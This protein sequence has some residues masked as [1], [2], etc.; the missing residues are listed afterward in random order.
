[1]KHFPPRLWLGF[2]SR[3]ESTSEAAFK[4][5]DRN[6]E[7]YKKSLEKILP[8]LSPDAR[9]FFLKPM[10]LHDGTL[11]L[12]EVG[13]RID[14]VAARRSKGDWDR[15]NARVR[16]FVL[17]TAG[18]F[19]YKL[20]Y[21]SVTEVQ[22]NFPGRISLFPAGKHP[23]FGDWGYDELSFGRKSAFRHEI[24]FSSGATIS[25]EFDRLSVKRKTLK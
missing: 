19:V 24:L 15:R 10:L 3:R 16:M 6:F 2:N 20:D 22:V 9:R 21:K 1:M 8:R 5:W 23:N 11:N 17:P 25:I 4:S 13:D 12:L 7:A 18:N 14:H